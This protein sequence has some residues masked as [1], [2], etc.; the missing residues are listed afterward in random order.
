MFLLLKNLLLKK[1]F[2]TSFDERL[3]LATER[4]EK[5]RKKQLA[6]EKLKKQPLFE[7]KLRRIKRDLLK[8]A[9]NSAGNKVIYALDAL[10]IFDRDEIIRPFVDYSH[11]TE[12]DYVELLHEFCAFIEK[13]LDYAF[14]VEL[15]IKDNVFV[16]Y[17]LTVE[18]K[19][20]NGK[21]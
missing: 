14:T 15:E 17:L 9:S 18:R 7:K 1:D 16:T 11:K 12:E 3:L 13:E 10:D 21:C 4:K 20:S 8:E 2:L 5:Q 6:K 19:D